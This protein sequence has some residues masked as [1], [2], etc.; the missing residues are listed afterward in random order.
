MQSALI[1]KSAEKPTRKL[2]EYGPEAAVRDE[3]LG[4]H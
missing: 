4:A 1:S 3:A 2:S